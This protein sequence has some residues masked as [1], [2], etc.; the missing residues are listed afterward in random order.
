M[1]HISL[2][3]F[4]EV[5]SALETHVQVNVFE[6]V[7]LADTI[8]NINLYALVNESTKE[9]GFAKQKQSGQYRHPTTKQYVQSKGSHE[10]ETINKT[11]QCPHS[12]H[13]NTFIA[14]QPSHMPPTW[15]HLV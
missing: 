13:T 12:Y 15:I 4:A 14:Y 3:G 5:V 2:D 10:I 7:G 1:Y 9:P 6:M 11:C 8:N